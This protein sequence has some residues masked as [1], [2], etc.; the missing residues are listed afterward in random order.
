VGE[1]GA[2][3]V[4]GPNVFAGYWRRP[5]L[6]ST[7]FTDDDWFRTGDLGRFDADGYLHLVGRSKDLII[8]GGLNVYPPEVEAVLD[9][10][11]GVVE[12]AVIGLPDADFGE[13]VVAVIVAED[14]AAID[15]A[16]VREAA[17]RQ[18]AGYKVPRR[19]EVVDAL[20]RNAMGKVE[21]AALRT[22]FR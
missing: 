8:S 22:R 20:P 7:E 5:D 19:V 17:R 9:D 11:D 13:M 2:V 6:A 21:K 4:R 14:G 10:L 1:A 16:T 18:L 3:E 15:T 12:S